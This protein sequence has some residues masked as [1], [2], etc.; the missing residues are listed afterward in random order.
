MHRSFVRIL[1]R[2]ADRARFLHN[3]CTNNIKAMLPGEV[4]EAFFVNVQA[5]VLAHGFVASFDSHHEIWMLPGDPAALVRHLSR[6][7]ISEDVTVELADATPRAFRIEIDQ[8]VDSALSS[9]AEAGCGAYVDGDRK[10]IAIW[11]TWRS[12]SLIVI[13]GSAE[14]IPEIP[15]VAQASLRPIGEEEFERLRIEARFPIIGVDI[16]SEN[17][18]PEADRNANAISYTKGCYLGQEPIARIDALGHVNKSL[19]L[20][21]LTSVDSS[22][23][24]VSSLIEAKL[25]TS[26]ET[27][28]DRNVV[29][30]LTSAVLD[31]SQGQY[32]GLSVVRVSSASQPLTLVTDD[33]QCLTANVV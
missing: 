3:F 23:V 16:S 1:V 30:I 22:D 9:N 6:Y 13:D 15:N 10:S 21:R 14:A 5:K 7:V 31:K 29:G 27:S 2:G 24:P 32:I 18:A 33:G 11:F 17:L 26:A 28:D 20:I 19:K 25:R 8:T 12:K 4:L